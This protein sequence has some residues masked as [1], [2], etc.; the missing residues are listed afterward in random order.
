MGKKKDTIDEKQLA[1]AGSAATAAILGRSGR[2]A[3]GAGYGCGKFGL[4]RNAGRSLPR[5]SR[6]RCLFS[7]SE[8]R[9]GG[10]G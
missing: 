1:I 7:K 8:L 6:T 3:N 4:L 5:T 2:N 10:K 9:N